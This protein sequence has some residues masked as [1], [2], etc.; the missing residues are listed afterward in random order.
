MPAHRHLPAC[1]PCPRSPTTVMIIHVRNTGDTNITSPWTVTMT[2][3]SIYE[4][5]VANWSVAAGNY[6]AIV[7]LGLLL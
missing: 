1:V 3:N 5:P 6:W 4:E 2:S 7:R